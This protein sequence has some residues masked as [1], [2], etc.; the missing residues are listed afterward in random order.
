MELKELLATL[1]YD[2]SPNFLLT[3]QLAEDRD[4]AHI[5]RKASEE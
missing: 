5:Y 1:E 4:N 3:E 2:R